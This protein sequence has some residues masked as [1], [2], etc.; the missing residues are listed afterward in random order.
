MMTSLDDDNIAEKIRPPNTNPFN[1]TE[2]Y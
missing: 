2:H 1:L